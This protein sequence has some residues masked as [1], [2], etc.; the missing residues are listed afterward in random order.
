MPTAPPRVCPRCRGLIT[1]RYCKTCRKP[2]P[3]AS[4]NKTR[5]QRELRRI[6]IENDPWCQWQSPTPGVGRSPECYRPATQADHIVPVSE[7]PELADSYENLQSLCH[8]HHVAKTNQ[9]RRRRS[10]KGDDDEFRMSSP[11][12]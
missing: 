5:A 2:S 12:S 9:D 3:S 8:D 10:G 1:G 4:A 11:W 6:K 7:A